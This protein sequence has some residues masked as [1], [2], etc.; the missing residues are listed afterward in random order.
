[1]DQRKTL[2]IIATVT[3]FLAAA[4]GVGIWLLDPPDNV[5]EADTDDADDAGF[6]PLEYIRS[7][8]DEAE[9]D[10]VE[11]DDDGLIDVVYGEADDPDGA[12]T[13]DDAAA[14]EVSTPGDDEADGSDPTAV[15]EV[16]ARTGEADGETVENGGDAATPETTQETTTTAEARR[17]RTTAADDSG[18]AATRDMDEAEPDAE[19]RQVRVTEYWIQVIAS[20]SLDRVRELQDDL[21]GRGL[22][23]RITSTEVSGE[24]FY[25]LRIGPYMD[26]GEAEK[27][28]GWVQDIDGFEPAQIWE[29]YPL[30]TVASR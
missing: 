10:L 5:A 1:M 16:P 4:I 28:L 6:D 26:R 18:R 2:I 25:R 7:N 29:E 9:E 27:F 12:A 24:M 23:G 11:P 30:R 13:G 3:I 8:G 21:E 22:P 20:K 14:D 19:P 17:D 15:A